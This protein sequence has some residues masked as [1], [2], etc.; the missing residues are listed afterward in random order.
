[1]R[2]Y[3]CYA[4]K[5][6]HICMHMYEYFKQEREREREREREGKLQFK[7]VLLLIKSILYIANNFLH[8]PYIT[9]I[10]SITTIKLLFL[11]A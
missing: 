8:V 7:L 11:R 1:V 4:R 10:I 2:V 9:T 6:T 5:V 3:D